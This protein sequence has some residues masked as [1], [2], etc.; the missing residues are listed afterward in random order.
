MEDLPTTR[1]SRRCRQEK[2]KRTGAK[3]YAPVA[4]PKKEGVDRHAPHAGDSVQVAEWRQRMATVEAKRDLQ[5]ESSNRRTGQRASAESRLDPF[6]G[7][8]RAK[9]QAVALWFAT[10]HNMARGFALLASPSL[11]SPSLATGTT[12]GLSCL[13]AI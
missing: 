2:E 10:V 13:P 5:G 9:G 11:A 1:T 4:K 8:R 6:V 7:P 3:V 12:P